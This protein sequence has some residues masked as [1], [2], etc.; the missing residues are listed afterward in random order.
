MRSKLMKYFI[1]LLSIFLSIPTYSN[2][3]S[4]SN[5]EEI[6]L[7]TVDGQIHFEYYKKLAELEDKMAHCASSSIVINKPEIS[8]IT[9]NWDHLTTAFIYFDAKT[10]YECVEPEL[11]EFALTSS[12]LMSINETKSKTLEATNYIAMKTPIHFAKAERDFFK[13]PKRVQTKFMNIEQF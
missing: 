10:Q 5:G 1:I 8:L 9:D 12:I 2:T 4:L 3:V 13:L 6:D 11:K 7:N